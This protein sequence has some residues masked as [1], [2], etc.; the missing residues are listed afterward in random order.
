MSFETLL[1]ETRGRAQIG[2]QRREHAGQ[3]IRIGVLQQ[4][5]SQRSEDC[6]PNLTECHSR[7]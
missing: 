6:S 2:V 7:P 1:V 4:V 5:A 3:G